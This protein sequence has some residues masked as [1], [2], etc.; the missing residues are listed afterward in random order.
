MAVAIDCRT[1][2][3]ICA[4]EMIE[5]CGRPHEWRITANCDA[6]HRF[7]SSRGLAH[8]RESGAR[9]VAGMEMARVRN[10][11]LMCLFLRDAGLAMF[12]RFGVVLSSLSMKIDRLSPTSSDCLTSSRN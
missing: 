6:P 3:R 11:R 10:L 7:T 2:S 12:R 9:L 8:V 1:G 4:L 5:C